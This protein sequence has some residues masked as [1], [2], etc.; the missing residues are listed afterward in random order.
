MNKVIS[1]WNGRDTVHERACHVYMWMIT[2]S[3]CS[4]FKHAYKEF[5]FL[6]PELHRSLGKELHR[7]AWQDAKKASGE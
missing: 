3:V 7:M 1:R 5:Q 6:W 2:R 4:S